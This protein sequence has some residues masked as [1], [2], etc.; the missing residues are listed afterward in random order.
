MNKRPET[1]GND[2]LLPLIAIVGPTAVGKTEIAIDLAERLGGEIVSADSRLFYRGMD[3]GTDKPS[4][5]QR[6]RLPHHLIDVVDPHEV[7]SLAVYKQAAKMAIA[8]IHSRGKLPFLVGGAGQYVRA[9]IENWVVPK[10]KPDPGLRLLL[11]SW[12]EEVHPKGLHT[13]LVALDPEAAEKID[14]RNVR[15]TIRALEVI[16]RTGKKFSEQRVQGTALY[17]SLV[18]GLTCPRKELYARIDARI[19][20]MMEAGLVEEVETLLTRGY[21]PDL[22]SFSAIGY[23]EIASYVRGELSLEEAV[24]AMKQHTRRFVRR[25]ANWFKLDDPGIKWFQ[26]NTDTVTEIEGV[27]RGFLSSAVR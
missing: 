26:V 1:S 23:R 24:S 12:A 16:F 27:I 14:Y 6:A 21:T 7:W 5:E 25:Q 9:I 8:D 10:V 11:E 13:R 19:Q 22:P 15:R 3:V 18:V 20:S 2:S 4:P 17:R